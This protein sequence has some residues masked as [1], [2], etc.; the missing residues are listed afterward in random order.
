M[1]QY[2]CLLGFCRTV[3]FPCR[4]VLCFVQDCCRFYRYYCVYNV[5]FLYDTCVSRA[6][7]WIEREGAACEL[8]VTTTKSIGNRISYDTKNFDQ[9][10]HFM[11][12][13]TVNIVSL[14]KKEIVSEKKRCRGTRKCQVCI[15]IYSINPVAKTFPH[16]IQTRK[17]TILNDV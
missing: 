2:A 13:Y 4:G 17:H 1:G 3:L 12:S 11:C 14:V 6:G 15:S 7:M 16:W 8:E 10:S 9:M 5:E